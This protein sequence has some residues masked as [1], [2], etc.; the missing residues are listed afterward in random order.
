[1]SQRTEAN[2]ALILDYF[3]TMNGA[4]SGRHLADFFAENVVWHL[5]QSSP[6]TQDPR[7]GRAAVM[8]LLQDGVDTYRRGTLKIDLQRVVADDAHVVA[9]F[10]L[11]AQ[12]ANGNDYDNQYLFLFSIADG[13]IDGVWEYLDTLYQSQKGAFDGGAPAK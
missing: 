2:K 3:A 8:A 13:R 10:T 12:L 4:G 5:P 9:Q 6:M 11:T 1:M 7:S